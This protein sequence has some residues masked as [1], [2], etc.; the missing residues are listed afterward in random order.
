MLRSF[1]RWNR[2]VVH[3][4]FLKENHNGYLAGNNYIITWAL[5]HLVTLAD[6]EYYGEQYKK[7]NQ[8][9]QEENVTILHAVES[10]SRAWGFPSPGEIGRVL[11]AKE[12]HNGYLAGNNYIITWA[13]YC[14]LI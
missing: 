4:G 3:G 9:E 8:I 6:P 5:G 12:N 7:W 2:A 1:M 10:G 11:G 14:C 13:A